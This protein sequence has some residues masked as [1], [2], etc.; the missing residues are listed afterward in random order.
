[1]SAS[2]YARLVCFF[3]MPDLGERQFRNRFRRGTGFRRRATV[4]PRHHLQEL[5]HL[6]LREQA[7]FRRAV[8]GLRTGVRAFEIHPRRIAG[9]GDLLRLHHGAALRQRMLR[10][11]VSCD[12]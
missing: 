6:P 1:M 3:V 12:V 7:D 8:H 9:V 11:G 2:S 10:R 5:A 4:V